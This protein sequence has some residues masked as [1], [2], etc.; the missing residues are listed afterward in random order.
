MK[1]IQDM[2]S[3]LEQA[4]AQ[5]GSAEFPGYRIRVS[6][7]DRNQRKKRKDAAAGHWAPD[8]GGQI[9]ITFEPKPAE[10]SAEPAQ[11]A[12]N[13]MADLIRALSRAE[14]RPGYGFVALKWFRDQV[15]PAVRPDWGSPESRTA[16]LREAIDAGMVLT[17]K[18]P[19]PK[20]P[21][22]P[23]TAVRVNRSLPAVSA[24]LG[25]P[26]APPD[27]FRPVAIR[28]EGLSDTVLR[29]RR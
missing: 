14:S 10:T 18:V 26:A 17:S 5:L 23:V 2:E 12:S 11:P 15:L 7:V 22:F 1:K 21:A 13:T 4:L 9:L 28:G 29:E 6:L 27:E 16:I 3:H 25:V 19:N 8:A 24:I 20:S